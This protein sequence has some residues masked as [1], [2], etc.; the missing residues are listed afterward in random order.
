M[1]DKIEV[2]KAEYDYLLWFFTSA[3]FGPA[4]GDVMLYMNEQYVSDG[5]TIPDEYKV[6]Y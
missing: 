1:S 5:G 4:H 2:D 3:D 6:E